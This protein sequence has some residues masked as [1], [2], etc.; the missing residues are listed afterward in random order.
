MKNNGFFISTGEKNGF[1][2]LKQLVFEPRYA[3]GCSGQWIAAG[4]QE[5]EVYYQNLST[6]RAE[7]IRKAK[8]ITGYDLSINFDLEE[9]ERL[10]AEEYARLRA[11][12]QA[13]FDATD[14]SAFQ[15]GKYAGRKVADVFAE[16]PGYVEWFAGQ[17]VSINDEGKARTRQCCI[18]LVAPIVAQRSANERSEANALIA[19]LGENDVR[20][21]ASR[22]EDGFAKS[23]CSQLLNGSVPSAKALWILAEIFAKFSG[24]RNSKA[25]V[26]AYGAIEAKLTAALDNVTSRVRHRAAP[27][28]PI[29]DVVYRD[30]FHKKAA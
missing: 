30:P 20:A 16:D 19:A 15:F 23:V 7:A 3:Q 11:E 4:C 21:V 28:K 1:Y 9:I 6:D 13:R 12:A 17:S 25:Y 10:K 22:E 8:E 14:W 26:A 18:D 2:T 29:G 24:R 27:A 5:K